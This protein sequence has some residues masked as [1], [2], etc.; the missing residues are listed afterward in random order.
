MSTE[1]SRFLKIILHNWSPYFLEAPDETNAN[2]L[3][4]C[5]DRALEDGVYQQELFVF[6]KNQDVIQLHGI[7][8]ILCPASDAVGKMVSAMLPSSYPHSKPTQS[9]HI[10]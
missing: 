3:L 6:T 4:N 2:I 10:Q 9:P 7:K 5:I 8:P 1:P